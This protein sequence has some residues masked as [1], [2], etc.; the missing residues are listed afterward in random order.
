MDYLQQALEKARRQRTAGSEPSGGAGEQTAPAGAWPRP[1]LVPS[2]AAVA[3]TGAGPAPRGAISLAWHGLSPIDPDPARLQRLRV[4]SR[5]G[6]RAAAPWDLLRARLAEEARRN[7]WRRIALVS[8]AAGTGRTTALANLAFSFARAPGVRLIALDLDLRAP[9]LGRL[10][11]QSP[12]TGMASGLAEVLEGRAPFAAAARRFGG[13]VAF[14]L[15]ASGRASPADLLGAPSAGQA[16]AAMDLAYAP[17]L[18]LMD[19]APLDAGLEAEAA[20]AL[21]DA[22]LILV[23]ANRATVQEVDA[24]ERAVAAITAVAGLVLTKA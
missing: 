11:G 6:G 8:A 17:D 7:G 2:A 5:E 16:L 15:A 3:Q 21:A 24:T 1:R 20:L 19:A 9:G 10:L 12:V 18:I 14:G 4:V 22:A 13:G 23:E